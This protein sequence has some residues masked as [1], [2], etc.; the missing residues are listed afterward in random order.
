MDVPRRAPDGSRCRDPV[1]VLMRVIP[2][3]L[4]RHADAWL[5]TAHLTAP[6]IGIGL[7]QGVPLR[8]LDAVAL[9]LTWWLV[10][11]DQRLVYGRG[12]RREACDVDRVDRHARRTRFP[13]TVLRGCC[14]ARWH[15]AGFRA[16]RPPTGLFK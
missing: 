9:L 7:I 10:L 11:V 16:S 3:F 15:G 2:E 13:R 12:G 4:R 5:W 8:P 6:T 14:C 1:A